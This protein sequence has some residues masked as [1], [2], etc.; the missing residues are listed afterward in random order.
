MKNGVVEVKVLQIWPTDQGCMVFVG[1][2]QKVF[3]IHVDL[4]VGRAIHMA[5]TGVKAERPL[6]HDLIHNIFAGLGVQ[7]QRI[8]VNDLV[9]QGG[10]GTY[11]ARLILSCENEL[12]KK[13]VEI[14]SRP[15]DAIA[16]ALHQKCP[17]YVS[18]EVFDAVEDASEDLKRINQLLRKAKDPSESDIDEEGEEKP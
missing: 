17:I 18:K 7:V 9:K 13:L 5:M 11:Y 14:D 6:T 4:N 10:G 12:G 16:L 3:V 15:S 8:V 2:N 1:N